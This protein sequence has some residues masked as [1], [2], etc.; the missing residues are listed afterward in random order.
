MPPASSKRA[1]W[2]LV[3]LLVLVHLSAV[4]YTLPLNRV[5]ELRL[6]QEHYERNDPT[7]IWPDGSIPE[8][9]C[10]IDD[11]QRR[12]AWLQGIMETTL[13]V[14]DFIM[15]IPFS[16]VAQRWGIRVVLWCNLIPRVF[17]SAWAV[18]VG[19]YS[20][21]LPTKAII[22]GPFLNVL[23]GEC[24]FQSTIFT[25]TSALTSEYVQRASYFSY[26]SS[27]SYV[28]SFMGPTLASFTMSTNL[29]LPFWL[30]ILLLTCAIPTVLL[31]P[32]TKQ[33][34]AILSTP[35]G[36]ISHAHLEEESGPL[37]ETTNP[38]P[39]RYTTAFETHTSIVQS[40]THSVR[41]LWRLVIGRQKFQILL[42][43]FFLTALASSDTKLLVQYISKRY[44]WT[45]A[46]AGYMLSA[47]ALVNFTLLAIVVPRI[48][49]ASMA[50]KTVH[51][52]EIRLNILGAEVSIIVSVL[53]VLCVA[54]AAK[55]WMMLTALIIYAL[56][57]A[58]P[59]FTMSLVKSP[60]IALA[61]SDIQD[62]SIVMLTKTLGSL[63]GAPLMAVLWV[64]AIKIGGV[65]LG[66]PY[67]VSACIYL[68]AAFVIARLRS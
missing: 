34:P 35:H 55:F 58:L 64:Q 29:W 45:F 49:R 47:K 1:I 19:H 24:V 66:L 13:V 7:L 5:I 37:L 65:G 43:S 2:P 52:S 6:C 41:K 50:T 62:F 53:G 36:I 30:N 28:V 27:T 10:K 61:H 32:V 54:M 9:L 4:L 20:H 16:F 31:L 42:C 8:K 21:V 38:S 18:V 11:V 39:D 17:M 63:V 59:V 56:G 23:G 60:L 25:L 12:L 14:C 68:I 26:I 46:E 51:G 48:I 15:T 67:F 57:S 33:T 3:L 22:A 44:E 40:I